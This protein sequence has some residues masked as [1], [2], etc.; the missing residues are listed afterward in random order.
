MFRRIFADETPFESN[1]GSHPYRHPRPLYPRFCYKC[2]EVLPDHRSTDCPKQGQCC[3]CGCS[4][5]SAPICEVP[6]LKCSEV[7]CV[8]PSWHPNVRTW[9]SAPPAAHIKRLMVNN[10]DVVET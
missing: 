4:N 5:H 6:H 2:W 10:P 7:N 3:F 1:H 8:V 9:C